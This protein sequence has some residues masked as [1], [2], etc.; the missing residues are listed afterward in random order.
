MKQAAIPK[1]SSE[2][3]EA[4]WWDA[5]RPEIEMEIRRRMKQK[6]SVSLGEL[7]RGA[8]VSQPVTL[9]IPKG[10]LET[11]RR[12]AAE[13]G[14]G[15]QTYIKML[16]REALAKNAADA[17]SGGIRRVPATPYGEPRELKTTS[18]SSQRIRF[19][20]YNPYESLY[21]GLRVV[22]RETLHLIKTLRAQG[23]SVVVEPDDGTKLNYL[24]EK[25]FRELLSD[26]I[27]AFV[28]GIPTSLILNLIANWVF[29][30]KRPKPDG[31][32]LVLEFDENGNK[33]RYSESGRPVTQEQFQS[34]LSA[35]EARKRR[36]EESRKVNTPYPGYVIPVH[37]E[38]TGKVVGWSKGFIVDDQ[39][40]TIA[41]DE[42]RICDD[43]TRER[44]QRGELRGFSIAGIVTKATCLICGA[45]Y[46]DCDHIAS[47]SYEGEK[48]TVRTTTRPAEIS[49]VK[50]PVQP[51]ARIRII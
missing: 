5:R 50:D 2:A 42:I 36:F 14:L 35:L 31:V 26:P 27:Y 32:N 19:R 16:L 17:F 44:I 38:H 4:E 51:L 43:E 37:L 46:V 20:S 12:L 10:D 3:K 21:P 11:A 6:P 29:Q 13:K 45:D 22:S 15:Y 40:K 47:V 48:C 7:I 23:H 49:I 8:K 33:V 9:R 34:I 1:F 18:E 24:A 30:L 25:G 41:T 28:I 39:K